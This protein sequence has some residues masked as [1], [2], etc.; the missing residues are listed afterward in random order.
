MFIHAVTPRPCAWHVSIGASQGAPLWYSRVPA[1]NVTC[2][3][4]CI[5]VVQRKETSVI[6]NTCRHSSGNLI[7]AYR[8]YLLCAAGVL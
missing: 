2:E 3:L 8:I 4:Y 1:G 6:A 5:I 7:L